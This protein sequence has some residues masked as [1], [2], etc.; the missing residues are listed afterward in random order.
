MLSRNKSILYL[1]F[2]SAPLRL[3]NLSSL[4]STL[5]KKVRNVTQ[6][7]VEDISCLSFL[8]RFLCEIE[9]P[10]WLLGAWLE[11]HFFYLP[12]APP[13]LPSLLSKFISLHP[14]FLFPFSSTIPQR[15]SDA[16]GC[17]FA[18][19]P[20]LLFPIVLVSVPYLS[21]LFFSSSPSLC[22]STFFLFLS[23]PWLHSS[24]LS[25]LNISHSIWL[26]PTSVYASSTRSMFQEVEMDQY[27]SH[28]EK[29]LKSF[30]Y[31]GIF[32]PKSRAHHM[33][34]SERRKVDGCAI[35]W[36]HERWVSQLPIMLK[37]DTRNRAG[38][39]I[40]WCRM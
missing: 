28:F 31:Q 17:F 40:L 38:N 19:S 39:Q 2:S 37:L 12:N 21:L 23:S 35:F 9:K 30:G 34:E 32:S 8:Q 27:D 1:R 20:S 13:H 15:K 29:T 16:N 26:L 4:F 5:L 24:S 18:C 33:N 22:L 10:R 3:V 11:N 25:V 36:K 6:A 14:A 7:W